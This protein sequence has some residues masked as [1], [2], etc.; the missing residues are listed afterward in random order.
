MWA[1]TTPNIGTR[2]QMMSHAWRFLKTT[3]Y[4]L[5]GNVTNCYSTVENPFYDKS[6]IRLSKNGSVLLGNGFLLLSARDAAISTKADQLESVTFEGDNRNFDGWMFDLER[7]SVA[8]RAASTNPAVSSPLQFLRVRT[9]AKTGCRIPLY[10]YGVTNIS[11]TLRHPWKPDDWQ[12]TW[13]IR[14]LAYWKDRMTIWNGRE[15]QDVGLAPLTRVVLWLVI[16]YM[17]PDHDSHVRWWRLTYRLEDDGSRSVSKTGM[18]KDDII[19]GVWACVGGAPP[20]PP[21]DA[22]GVQEAEA[23]VKS[24][25]LSTGQGLTNWMVR[26][27]DGGDPKVSRTYIRTYPCG[28][29]PSKVMRL[30]DLMGGFQY[31]AKEILKEE[32][33]KPMKE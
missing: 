28:A 10:S 22:K 7:P 2:E 21:L 11:Q 5:G 13:P 14:A 26:I 25:P 31:E 3:Y 19:S 23:T 24:L 15:W 18:Y 4:V 20:I 6:S 16:D 9:D 1:T 29:V 17:Y 32:P 8:D 30:L 27:T 33:D 12:K